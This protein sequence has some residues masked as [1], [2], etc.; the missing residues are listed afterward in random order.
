MK[1][2]RFCLSSPF[3]FCSSASSTPVGL[4]L[5]KVLRRTGDISLRRALGASKRAVFSQY[6]VEAGLVGVTGGV[7]GIGVTWLGL[8][9]H[10]G[11]VSRAGLRAETGAAGL[12]HAL[13]GDR[14]GSCLRA[15]GSALPDV[16]SGARA[17]CRSAEGA[18]ARAF[19][20]ET[21]LEIGPILRAML[22]NKPGYIL[23]ALQIALTMTIMVNAVA[24]IQERSALM[25]E[26]ERCRRTEHLL[27]VESGVST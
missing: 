8:V 21:H 14:V 20:G 17:S 4:L 3:F 5:A 6:I 27:S 11:A 19:D 7:V 1:A 16:A 25:G 24:I 10:T 2:C 15:G 18:I 23:I 22:R 26:A 13:C 12:G 9:G